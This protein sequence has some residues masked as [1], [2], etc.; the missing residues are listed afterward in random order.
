M[1]IPSSTWSLLSVAVIAY[2]AVALERAADRQDQTDRITI[3]YWE[4]WT[5]SEANEMRKIVDWYNRS[6]SKVRVKF[7]STANVDNKTRLAASGGS[8]PDIAGLWE[9]NVSSFA[10]ANAL[11]D[12]TP[13]ATADGIKQSQYID[14]YW[15]MFSYG[16]KLCALPTTPSST[17]MHYNRKFMPATMQSP[18]TAPKTLEELD[19]LVDKIS[20]KKKDGSIQLAGFLP[21]EPGWWSWGWGYLFGGKLYDEKTQKLTMN[22]PENIAALTWVKSYTDRFGQRETQSFQSSFGNFSSPQAAFF[23]NKVASVIQGVWLANYIH[24]FARGMD[25]YAA[26]IPH[27][28]SRPDLAGTNFLGCDVMIIPKG[29]KHPKEA[30]DF[31]K[32]VQRQ[33]VMETIC[34]AHGKNS[35]LTQ[36]SDQFFQKHMNK[37]IR[38]FDRLAREKNA[39]RVAKIGMFPQIQTEFN[40]AVQVVNLGEKTPKEALDEAQARMEP[41]VEKYLRYMGLKQ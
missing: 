19:A 4:K 33:D 36:V 12:L 6:Q 5:G 39:V 31:I 26:P 3:T 21:G 16:G 38:L 22:C 35:P 13:F 40:N 18:E 28:A 2:A 11:V 24:D 34:A 37:E 14:N 25:W 32:F 9:H 15:Q 27:P 20:L 8:P 10:D 30:W 1:K 17:S 29:S 7:L 41:L 23:S